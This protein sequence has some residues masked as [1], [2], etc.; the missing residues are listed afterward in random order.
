MM[1]DENG[2]E[3]GIELVL[4]HLKETRAFD[5]TGY[6]RGTLTR[7]IEKRMEQVGV[8]NH[9]DYVDF[10]EVH[11]EEFEPLFN[12]ILINVTSFFRDPEAWDVLRD[13][14]LPELIERS[15]GGPI[16]LWSAGC[17]SG[18][19]AYSAVMLLAEALGVEGVK[20]R[21]KVYATDVDEEAL[22]QAR[23][24]TYTQ[25]EMESL[26]PALAKKY[27]EPS[28]STWTFNPDLR[29]AVIFGRHDLL[30]D[31]P[32]SRVDLL[33]CRN[34]L[35]YFNSEVQTRLVQ[36]LHFSLASD[37]YLLLGK[38]EMLLGTGELFEPVD[39][40]R[41]LFRKLI[42]ATLRGRLLA[43]AS[44][45]N[46][47]YALTASERIVDAAF[48]HAADPQ[49]VLDGDGFLVA[50]N[51]R[52]RALF[53]IQPEAV[54][55]PFQDLEIS[56][57]PI[58]L[59]SSIDEARSE[60]RAVRLSEVPRWT[61]SGELTV[62][63]IGIAPLSRD[64]EHLGVVISFVD[65]TRHRQLQEE[66]EQ[67]HRELEV[68][69]EELQSANEELETTNEELQSTIEELET[70]N[71]ELQ[72]TNEELETM[73]E[74]LSSTN[75]ELHAINDEL[76]DRTGEVDRVNGYLESILTGLHASVIVIDTDL[77]VQV[78]NGRSF[79]MWGVRAEEVEGRPF[80]GLDLG[81]PVAELREPVLAALAG[82]PAEAPV[83]TEATS[84]RGGVMRC[85]ARVNAL[86]GAAARV[87][88]A[89]VIIEELPT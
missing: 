58:E 2:S 62:L 34:T 68:A 84:R 38:V 83:V 52:A 15:D 57:R 21:V 32:I 46:A 35:M 9:I 48:E 19:E 29:R 23:L 69:Y 31:A 50:V 78:W 27:F 80:F 63:D 41:R 24:A 49:L 30:Q 65:V 79:D 47:A 75:E 37:G 7:R 1:A 88:G 82:E 39:V 6:K 59:R 44:P 28:G 71:E 51:A 18:Q 89:I 26:S 67:T 87:E 33:L 85:A 4:D 11:P 16:R 73:N 55:R 86:W 42:P 13:V 56:Y 40:K 17:S 3:A 66:L 61:P 20:D 25:R 53:G 8:T 12:T 5:F 60:G 45:D 64:G 72:S 76:R 70:T 81:F 43:M 22:D 10:L 74:E 54:G 14:V 36:N 77:L